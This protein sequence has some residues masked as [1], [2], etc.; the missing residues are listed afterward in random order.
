MTTQPARSTWL[1]KLHDLMLDRGWSW[2]PDVRD[3]FRTIDPNR[4]LTAGD[5]PWTIPSLAPEERLEELAAYEEPGSAI[6]ERRRGRRN[7]EG[8][9]DSSVWLGKL[10]APLDADSAENLPRGAVELG[11]PLVCHFAW[12]R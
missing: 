11:P 12:Q 6:L 8:W 4:A 9:A 5:D 10:R 1:A 3:L 2:R 7:R